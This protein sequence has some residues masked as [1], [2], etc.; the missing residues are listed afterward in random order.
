M[1]LKETD[2]ERLLAV[3]KNAAVK[4]GEAIS[5]FDIN[6]ILIHKK[7]DMKS[8]AAEILTEADLKSQEIILSFL[9][10]TLK[11]FDLGLLSE[12]SIDD[13]SRFEKDFFWCI[14]PL[15][16]T[17][18]F[19]ENTDGYCVN[20]AL[21]SNI[22]KAIFGIV[23]NPKTDTLYFNHPTKGLFKNKLSYQLPKKN[24]QLTLIFDRSFLQTEHYPSVLQYLEAKGYPT[25]KII[26]YG[27]AGMNAIWVLESETKAAY[28][29]F[30]KNTK[31]GGSL[32]DYAATNPLFQSSNIYCSTINGNPLPLNQKNSFMNE[33]GI[34][35]S[36][37]S[38]LQEEIMKCFYFTNDASFKK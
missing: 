5:K 28:F 35:F 14:D 6:A 2:I 8:A 4:A 32:W 27:G 13:N 23:Y 29:K 17:L 22:G 15:D 26:Q 9:N 37:D 33:H 11:E 30:P 21:V 10:P 20:I 36:N 25:P 31:G 1:H 3:G 18:P 12:E 24:N 16:G 7:E 34:I 38:D 19:T